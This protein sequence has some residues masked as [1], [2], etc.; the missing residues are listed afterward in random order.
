ML[1]A[2]VRVFAGHF[3]RSVANPFRYQIT[4]HTGLLKPGHG[5]M[6]HGVSRALGQ[7]QL[8]IYV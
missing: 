7:F 4:V 6:P 5:A 8:L 1:G 3:Q 2:E